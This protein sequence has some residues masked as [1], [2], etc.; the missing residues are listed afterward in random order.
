MG[1]FAGYNDDIKIAK[2]YSPN[3]DIEASIIEETLKPKILALNIR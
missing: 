3:I 1:D 2:N